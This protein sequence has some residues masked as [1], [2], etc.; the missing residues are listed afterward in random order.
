MPLRNTQTG[1]PIS[2]ELPQA[3]TQPSAQP[4]ELYRQALQGLQ[5]ESLVSLMTS[6][7]NDMSDF[8]HVIRNYSESLQSSQEQTQQSLHQR[9]ETILTAVQDLQNSNEILQTVLQAQVEK[10]S[11]KTAAEAALKFDDYLKRIIN[12][13]TLDFKNEAKLISSLLDKS[14]KGLKASRR[15]PLVLTISIICNFFL[16][17]I[18]LILTLKGAI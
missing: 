18:I 5:N 2:E 1:Q 13:R 15:I 4:S 6:L 12:Q 8:S 10:I 16:S 14:A 7:K 17:V 9:E 3:T 11:S